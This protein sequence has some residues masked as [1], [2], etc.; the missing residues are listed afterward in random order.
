MCFVV[1][2][3]HPFWE[4]LGRLLEQFASLWPSLADSWALWGVPE[5]F[6]GPSGACLWGSMANF[7]TSNESAGPSGGPRGF[8]RCIMMFGAGF[9][10]DFG[11]KLRSGMKLKCV[12]GCK[13]QALAV[14]SRACFW[15]PSATLFCKLWEHYWSRLELCDPPWAI[16]GH[17]GASLEDVSVPIGSFLGGVVGGLLRILTYVMNMLVLWGERGGSKGCA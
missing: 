2:I 6:P 5:G 4:L 17:S 14:L 16:P 10:G 1:T 15:S 8:K 3:C 12:R 11:V 7:D 9:W 13:Y